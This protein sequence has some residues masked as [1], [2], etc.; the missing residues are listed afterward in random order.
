MGE[1]EEV[2]AAGADLTRRCQIDRA[3]RDL[4]GMTHRSRP[5][6]RVAAPVSAILVAISLTLTLASCGGPSP[7]EQARAKAA[8]QA[9]R[10]RQE[11]EIERLAQ[12]AASTREGA[13]R[14]GLGKLLT[15]A[16]ELN[17]RLKVGLNYSEYFEQVA[18]LR[19]AYDSSN[20]DDLELPCIQGVGV[21]LERALNEFAGAAR[22]WQRCMDDYACDDDANTSR[23]Q[24]RWGTADQQIEAAKDALDELGNPDDEMREQAKATL[25]KGRT[26]PE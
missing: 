6:R 11:A 5:H 20:F 24:T 25:A 15:S 21:R 16:G 13:C 18:D 26:T 8:A 9:A 10:E 3:P 17:S 19:V 14:D 22:S 23:L 1:R 4:P 12:Q 2:V 7:E